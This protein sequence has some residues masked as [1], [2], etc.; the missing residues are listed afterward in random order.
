MSLSKKGKFTIGKNELVVEIYFT[1]HGGSN[2]ASL[3]KKGK[4]IIGKERTSI[5]L[6]ISSVASI[7]A[8]QGSCL[9]KH[10]NNRNWAFH[11]SFFL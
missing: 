5:I 6:I 4:F 3:S 7:E 9:G 2:G 10:I 8:N 11:F 1:L